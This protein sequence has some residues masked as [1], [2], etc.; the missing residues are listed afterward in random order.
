M[1]YLYIILH[2]FYQ[3]QAI[4]DFLE[5]TGKMYSFRVDSLGETTE[6]LVEQF[7]AINYK[8]YM[9]KENDKKVS[10]KKLKPKVNINQFIIILR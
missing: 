2:Y 7:R 10:V 5:A 6:K 9:L 8:K 3:L 4:G 1:F